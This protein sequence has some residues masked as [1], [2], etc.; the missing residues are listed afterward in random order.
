MGLVREIYNSRYMISALVCKDLV[1]R[2]RNSV[3]GFL[4]HFVIPLVTFC[5]Y[6]I[7]FSTIRIAPI[8]DFAI[9]LSSGLFAFT[10]MTSNLSG[11]AAT[12]TSNASMVKK[13]Y[14][15]REIL[16]LSRIIST[17][18]VMLIGYV[19]VFLAIIL[20]GFSINIWTIWL[21]PFLL[22]LVLIFTLGYVFLFS[23]LNVYLRDIQYGLQSISMVFFFLTPM[24][25][26]SST[27]TGL[28]KTT[29]W[30]NPFTYYVEAIHDCIYFGEMPSLFII[31][32]CIVFSLISCIVGFVIFEK[33]KSG[34]A[35][36]L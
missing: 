8:P 3:L 21:F 17:F 34:F 23:A 31:C 20:T 14:F 30:L 1:G 35:E 19:I 6:F 25:F 12:I 29:I 4:W 33:L 16:V 7:A 10:F 26:L 11:G 27:A 24:Y 28:L 13:M 9:Y 2:Y 36:R 22:I 18:I 5:V 15:P 32:M